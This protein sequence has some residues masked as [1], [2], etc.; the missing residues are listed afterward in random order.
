MMMDESGKKSI[1]PPTQSLFLV[2]PALY[3]RSVTEYIVK[4]KQNIILTSLLVLKIWRQWSTRSLWTQRVGVRLLD[5]MDLPEGLYFVEISYY[6]KILLPPVISNYCQPLYGLICGF[7][8][9]P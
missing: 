2:V 6:Q 5:I 9:I 8:L 3:S 1:L 4:T 7:L